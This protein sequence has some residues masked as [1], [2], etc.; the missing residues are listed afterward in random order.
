MASSQLASLPEELR[1]PRAARN[2]PA[3]GASCGVRGAG[4]EQPD[5]GPQGCT[6]GREACSVAAAGTGGEG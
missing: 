2:G 6:A 4:G 3:M 1:R 5:G